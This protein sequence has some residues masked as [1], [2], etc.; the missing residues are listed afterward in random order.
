MR[1][2]Y[3]RHMPA[4]ALGEAARA[5][6]G[7]ELVSVLPHTL[8]RT[9]EAPIGLL[10]NARNSLPI[11]ESAHLPYNQFLYKKL[12]FDPAKDFEPIVNLF[13]NTQAR[14]STPRSR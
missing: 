6:Q 5:F 14:W 3:A 12:S 7:S 11:L 1:G 4:P 13:F 2:K 8:P 9:S 10:K